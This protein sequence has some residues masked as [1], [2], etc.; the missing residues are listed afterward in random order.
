MP[1]TSE[2]ISVITPTATHTP[3]VI[4][5]PA[6]DEATQASDQGRSFWVI[7]LLGLSLLVVVVAIGVVIWQAR[8]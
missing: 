8:A 2:L 3:A 4:P 6:I 1:A 7:P 5:S